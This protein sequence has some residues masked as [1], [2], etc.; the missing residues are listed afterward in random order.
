MNGGDRNQ[1]RDL[2]TISNTYAPQNRIHN[3]TYCQNITARVVTDRYRSFSLPIYITTEA[4]QLLVIRV[5]I[6]CTWCSSVKTKEYT[7]AEH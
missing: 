2:A 6:V 4:R 7:C 3:I 1:A 5:K